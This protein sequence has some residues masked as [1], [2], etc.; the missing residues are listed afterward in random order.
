MGA[1]VPNL[2]AVVA[3]IEE[4]FQSFLV[5]L[6]QGAPGGACKASLAKVV[7]SEDTV[8]NSEPEEKG[9]LGP[10][11]GLPDSVPDCF[12]NLIWGIAL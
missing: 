4:V 10:K 2:L 8:L 1:P 3:S 12:R 9:Y 7:P 5:V 11:K 6:T